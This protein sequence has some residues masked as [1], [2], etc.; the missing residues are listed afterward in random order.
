[1]WDMIS[2]TGQLQ[3]LIRILLTYTH[4]GGAPCNQSKSKLVSIRKIK[5]YA[6]MSRANMML[7]WC[8]GHSIIFIYQIQLPQSSKVHN[9]TNLIDW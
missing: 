9:N 4:R 5:Q 3:R 1:M 6:L 2:L 7:W 8:R